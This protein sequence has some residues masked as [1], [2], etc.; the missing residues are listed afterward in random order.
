MHSVGV[1]SCPFQ[2]CLF[3]SVVATDKG[4][5]DPQQMTL[6]IP[7][8]NQITAMQHSQKADDVAI[9]IDET[10]PLIN[11]DPVV[12]IETVGQPLYT[13]IVCVLP[14]L[15]LHFVDVLVYPLEQLEVVFNIHNSQI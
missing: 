14:V 3:S 7:S 2:T 15:L 6:Q 9:T 11:K 4:N 10:A 12:T 1:H 13:P 5:T 8:A